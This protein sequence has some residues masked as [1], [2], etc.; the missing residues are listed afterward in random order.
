MIPMTTSV[1]HINTESVRRSNLTLVVLPDQK[2]TALGDLYWDD[3]ESV[4]SVER[5]QYNY[6]TF[7]MQSNCSL[8]IDVKHS[9]NDGQTIDYIDVYNTNGSTVE[10]QV[11]GQTVRAH[12]SNANSMTR[13]EANIDLSAKE[14]NERWTVLWSSDGDCNLI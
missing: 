9:G 7:E 8:V 4:D 2:R 11:D 3:G 12:P 1:S 5:L 14:K 10:A 6:Y 13:I